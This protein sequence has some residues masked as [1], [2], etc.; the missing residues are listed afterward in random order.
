MEEQTPATPA[1][2]FRIGGVSQ[3]FTAAGA[4][5]LFERARLDLDAPVQQYLPSF[6][7][8]EWPISTRQLMAHTAGIRSQGGEGGIFHAACADDPERLAVN[9]DSIY[10]ELRGEPEKTDVIEL[11]ERMAALHE[12]QHPRSTGGWP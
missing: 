5:L 12:R 4:G 7:E 10:R 6:P 3:V 11:F 1:T 9:V 8:K 2:L